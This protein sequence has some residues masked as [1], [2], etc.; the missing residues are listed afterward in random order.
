MGGNGYSSGK[1]DH[2]LQV[3]TILPRV[4]GQPY[5][6][7]PLRRPPCLWVSIFWCLFLALYSQPTICRTGASVKNW[8]P[9]QYVWFRWQAGLSLKVLEKYFL[10]FFDYIGRTNFGSQS[11]SGWIWALDSCSA[12]HSGTCLFLSGCSRPCKVRGTS[13]WIWR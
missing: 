8:A 1:G 7:H 5:P 4:A 10:P 11:A 3:A 2:L 6:M 12:E 13:S 9:L